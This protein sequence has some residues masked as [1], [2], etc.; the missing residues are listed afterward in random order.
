MK[1][2]SEFL[3]L[4]NL[5]K[6]KTDA[7]TESCFEGPGNSYVGRTEDIFTL[8]IPEGN[9]YEK[10]RRKPVVNEPN[11]QFQKHLNSHSF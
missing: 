2:I 6:K 8:E 5:V 7:K 11:Y 1:A 4:I 3:P 9:V 10:E